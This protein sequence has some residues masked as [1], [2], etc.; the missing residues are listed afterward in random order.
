MKRYLVNRLQNTL[1]D[2]ATGCPR[3]LYKIPKPI[4]TPVV[5][6]F[7]PVIPVVMHQLV[8][9]DFLRNW[10]E[11]FYLCEKD[12]TLDVYTKNY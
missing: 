7:I 8:T 10:E 11:K 12:V 5:H 3:G 4:T 1:T 6:V 2:I 9:Q